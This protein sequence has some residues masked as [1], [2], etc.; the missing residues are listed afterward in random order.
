MEKKRH[1]NARSP[2]LRFGLFSLVVF[3]NLIGLFLAVI[4]WTDG[5]IIGLLVVAAFEIPF[6]LAAIT[7]MLNRYEKSNNRT[8]DSNIPEAEPQT[9]DPLGY[10][11]DEHEGA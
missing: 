10:Q 11:C 5:R 3:S 4:F 2:G 1:S 8:V 6:L 9:T 7:W